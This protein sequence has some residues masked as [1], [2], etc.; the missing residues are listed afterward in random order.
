MDA[1]ALSFLFNDLLGQPTWMWDVFLT[2]VAGVLALDPFPQ[3]RRHPPL[4]VSRTRL[5]NDSEPVAGRLIEGR[6]RWIVRP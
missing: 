3:Q 1:P 2:L 6:Q 5:S 4:L